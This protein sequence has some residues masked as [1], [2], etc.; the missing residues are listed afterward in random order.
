MALRCGADL[1]VGIA[2]P[3]G[4]G[5]PAERFARGGV[6]LLAAAGPPGGLWRGGALSDL[7]QAAAA[8][9]SN[10]FS[11]AL[12]PYL[13]EGLSFASARQKGPGAAASP[14]VPF[15]RP[16]TTCWES[17]T[18]GPSG[19]WRRRWS[20]LPCLGWERPT[21]ARWNRRAFVP[22]PPCG[23][24]AGRGAEEACGGMPEPAAEILRRSGSG[25]AVRQHWTTML[26]EFLP[27]C[28]P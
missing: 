5:P 17:N 4:G 12:Q 11:Q 15:W 23:E 13:K 16:P 22:P 24:T 20:R 6:A 10:D 14:A 3:V 25:N 8:L 7:E 1:V 18:C 26:G 21:T 19:P 28:A 9:D 2:G 27:G